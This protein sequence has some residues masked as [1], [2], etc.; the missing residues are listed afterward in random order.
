[1]GEDSRIHHISR[2]SHIHSFMSVYTYMYTYNDVGTALDQIWQKIG[3]LAGHIIKPYDQ[4]N[5]WVDQNY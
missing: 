2:A 3:N 5:V 4:K 1:M